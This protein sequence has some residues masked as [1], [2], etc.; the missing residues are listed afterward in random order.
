VGKG[1]RKG[2]KTPFVGRYTQRKGGGDFKKNGLSKK[3]ITF[4]LMGG[5]KRAS[6]GT[7]IERIGTRQQV[8]G[9]ECQ[10]EGSGRDQWKNSGGGG[11]GKDAEL[12]PK[13]IIPVGGLKGQGKQTGGG[14]LIRRQKGVSLKGKVN[15]HLRVGKFFLK[16]K[17]RK[18]AGQ[19]ENGS[20][21][22]HFLGNNAKQVLNGNR[23]TEK[24]GGHEKNVPQVKQNERARLAG[25]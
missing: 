3:G 9:S 4:I 16:G 5:G 14:K 13:A 12:G 21:K 6:R 7:K 18:L 8:P 2:N 11:G 20:V 10:G 25:D 19:G 1:R 24:G 15:C 23:G 17:K 22:R